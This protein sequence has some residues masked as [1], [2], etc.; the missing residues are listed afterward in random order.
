MSTAMQ[1]TD[2]KKKISL[3]E[4]KSDF[5][6]RLNVT[7]AYVSKLVGRGLPIVDGKV[8]IESAQKWMRENTAA[9]PGRPK[10]S[11]G[12]GIDLETARVELVQLQSERA[13][14]DNAKLRGELVPVEEV[15]K[16]MRAASRTTRDMFI[17][18]SSRHGAEIAGE[19]GVD[20]GTFIGILETHIR[21]ALNEAA[22]KPGVFEDRK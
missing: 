21:T 22:D 5:A 20:P 8:P 9:A 12:T 15:K 7:P 16:A 3:T 14:L 13:R 18:F 17:N 6:R 1:A 10:G 19:I 11:N 4:S 2:S